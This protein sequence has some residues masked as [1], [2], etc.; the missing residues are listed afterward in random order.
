MSKKDDRTKPICRYRTSVE[1][2]VRCYGSGDCRASRKTGGD[3]VATRNHTYRSVS[4]RTGSSYSRHKEAR[5]RPQTCLACRACETASL[6]ISPQQTTVP[7]LLPLSTTN[8]LPYHPATPDKRRPRGRRKAQSTEQLPGSSRMVSSRSEQS[9]PPSHSSSHSGGRTEIKLHHSVVV[10]PPPHSRL[11]SV[12]SGHVSPSS[13]AELRKWI[14]EFGGDEQAAFM[15]RGLQKLQL[16]YERGK[17]EMEQR[18]ADEA[19]PSER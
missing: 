15:A 3:G 4:T 6:Q 18:T 17:A 13:D 11:V 10:A 9:S 19:P 12:R 1:Q 16:A 14:V 8:H 5:L 2:L 7:K